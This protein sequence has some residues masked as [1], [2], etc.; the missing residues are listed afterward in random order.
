MRTLAVWDARDRRACHQPDH[1]APL[2][3]AGEASS[4]AVRRHRPITELAEG[5]VY[6]WG[7]LMAG[8]MMGSLPVASIGLILVEQMLMTG[9]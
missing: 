2:R 1:L 4:S 9:R 8:A 5:D 7:S 6:D 3:R